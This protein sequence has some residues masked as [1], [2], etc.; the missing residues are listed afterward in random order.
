MVR[1]RV[2]GVTAALAVLAVAILLPLL[3]TSLVT[4]VLGAIAAL[5][6]AA[7]LAGIVRLVAT[8]IGRDVRQA[9][10]HLASRRRR[11]TRLPARPDGVNAHV[12]DPVRL[13]DLPRRV[14][15]AADADALQDGPRSAAGPLPRAR[16]IAGRRRPESHRVAG[17]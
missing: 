6:A 11:E 16:R 8:D 15:G 5:V 1:R 17:T 13:L 10:G 2:A 14:P 7:A 9:L 4:T 3:T 12:V